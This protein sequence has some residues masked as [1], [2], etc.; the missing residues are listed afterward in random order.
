MFRSLSLSIYSFLSDVH[1]VDFGIKKLI[2]TV[3][4]VLCVGEIFSFSWFSKGLKMIYQRT[5]DF[6]ASSFILLIYKSIF[7]RW[8]IDSKNAGF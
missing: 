3:N 2:F 5:T 7:V 6:V 8:G 1:E 4:F